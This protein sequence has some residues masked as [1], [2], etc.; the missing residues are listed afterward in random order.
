MVGWISTPPFTVMPCSHGRNL[1]PKWPNTPNMS[2]T[3]IQRESIIKS[4]KSNIHPA[5]GWSS[6]HPDTMWN[7]W[8]TWTKWTKRF[9]CA[10]I[11][12]SHNFHELLA[13]IAKHQSSVNR[14]WLWSVTPEQLKLAALCPPSQSVSV[15]FLPIWW[16]QTNDIPPPRRWWLG[17]LWFIYLYFIWVD[18]GSVFHLVTSPKWFQ[19]ETLPGLLEF[20]WTSFPPC[21]ESKFRIPPDLF[22]FASR[23]EWPDCIS[24]PGRRGGVVCQMFESSLTVV[25]KTY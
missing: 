3:W 15:L 22:A 1:A 24:M 8:T 20:N 2:S 14:G 18:M 25:V 16:W 21:S 10:H 13:M 23:H 9:E 6:T 7:I 5:Y 17:D 12:I 19:V 11:T 4:F